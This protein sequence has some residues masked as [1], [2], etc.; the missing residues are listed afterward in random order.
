MNFLFDLYG[1]LVDIHTDEDMPR[2]WEEFATLLGESEGSDSPDALKAEYKSLCALHAAKKADPL[3]EFD[4]LGVFCE[5]LAKRGLPTSDAPRLAREFRAL[6]R[7]KLRTFPHVPE[8][9]AELRATGSGVYLVSNAQTCFTLDELDILG[10]TPLLDGI[11]ISSDAGVKKP[12]PRIFEIARERFSLE[13]RCVYVGNDMRDDVLGAYRAG[14]PTVYIETEQSGRYPDME[15][16]TPL[17][18][19]DTHAD[20]ERILLGIAKDA[21]K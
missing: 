21:D 19:A 2:L 11:L 13:G 12:S 7:E 10:L 4:L 6:S 17:A 9:L 15:L 18:V 14:I 5:M 1:T 20:L 8:M 16:P 3:E